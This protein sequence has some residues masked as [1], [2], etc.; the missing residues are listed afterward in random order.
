MRKRNE[1]KRN[2]SEGDCKKGFS[3][4]VIEKGWEG[5]KFISW[6]NL[7]KSFI[8]TWTAN[9]RGYGNGS[10]L[11]ERIPRCLKTKALRTR[12]VGHAIGRWAIVNRTT[13][14]QEMERKT[15]CT[16]M[17][18]TKRKKI[19]S[20]V[21]YR[22]WGIRWVNDSRN[23]NEALQ[24]EKREATEF[25]KRNLTPVVISWKIKKS[26]WWMSSRVSPFCNTGDY[27]HIAKLFW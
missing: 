8:V 27:H 4:Y 9:L 2:S 21:C 18:S 25:L 14:Q 10:R 11:M 5:G 7:S 23:R 15:C 6:N 3:S 16:N 20:S 12:D 22:A 26:F 19:E 17:S 13:S 1:R 24:R